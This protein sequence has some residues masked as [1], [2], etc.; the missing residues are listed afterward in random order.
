MVVANTSI[1]RDIGHP[2][3]FHAHYPHLRTDTWPGRELYFA[4]RHPVITIVILFAFVNVVL[5]I[6]GM[7]LVAP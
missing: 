3:R 6:I 5:G 1:I 7:P 2:H 4:W